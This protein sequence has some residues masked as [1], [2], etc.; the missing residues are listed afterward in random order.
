MVVMKKTAIAVVALAALSGVFTYASPAYAHP[1]NGLWSNGCAVTYTMTPDYEAQWGEPTKQGFARIA[2]LTGLT[3]TPSTGSASIAYRVNPTLGIGDPTVIDV[4]MGR[5]FADGTVEVAPRDVANNLRGPYVTPVMM[6]YADQRI[7]LHET[8]HVLG[9]DHAAP[10]PFM[11]IMS[12]ALGAMSFGPSDL[13]GLADIATT[14]GCI[15]TAT[16][17]TYNSEYLAEYNAM[18]NMASK[19]VPFKPASS[20][21]VIKSGDPLPKECRK[22]IK[23]SGILCSFT[24]VAR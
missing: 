9:L 11:E 5:A 13:H 6:K 3:F 17:D 19:P 8:L 16:L 15:P 14:N 7:P 10:G 4:V 23:K 2:A 21:T 12:P 22:P 20:G 1:A 24:V 18:M